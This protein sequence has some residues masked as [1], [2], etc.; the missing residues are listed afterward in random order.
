MFDIQGRLL[1]TVNVN[2]GRFEFDIQHFSNGTYIIRII[3]SGEIY[4][5]LIIKE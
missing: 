2:S 5:R 3:T 1:E 4:S